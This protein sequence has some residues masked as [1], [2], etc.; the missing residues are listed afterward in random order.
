MKLDI[1]FN[2]EDYKKQSKKFLLLGNPNHLRI[3]LILKEANKPLY[4]EEIRAILEKEGIYK[5]RENT[6]KALHKL[7][8]TGFIKKEKGSNKVGDVYS[9]IKS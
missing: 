3:L 5:H 7:V 8:N 2:K 6:H 4:T 9:L 1:G